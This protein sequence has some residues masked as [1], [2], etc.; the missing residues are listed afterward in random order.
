M[1]YHARRCSGYLRSADSEQ[2]RPA[3]D[4]PAGLI[5]PLGVRSPERPCQLRLLGAGPDRTGRRGHRET[6]PSPTEAVAVG[7]AKT[8]RNE[9]LKKTVPMR[10]G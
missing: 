9:P 6:W 4:D 2:G 5:R 10:G 3:A 1:N 8:P 7:V